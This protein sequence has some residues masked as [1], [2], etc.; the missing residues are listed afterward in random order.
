MTPPT[1]SADKSGE[2]GRLTGF[3]RGEA[4]VHEG[5]DYLNVLVGG[6]SIIGDIRYPNDED[7][8]NATLI[9]QA[10]TVANETGRTPRE[11]V[12]LLR[13]VVD[14]CAERPRGCTKNS[15]VILRAAAALSRAT[16]PQTDE[17]K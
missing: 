17:A 13:S 10:F 3:T 16:P 8:A 11:L 9:A 14:Q 12:E 4:E 2:A 15:P 5:Q 1:H 6:E 7:R